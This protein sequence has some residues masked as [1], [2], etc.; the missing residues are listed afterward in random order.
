VVSGEQACR[1]T[2]PSHVE[3][4][5]WSHSNVVLAVLLGRLGCTS[6][7]QFVRFVPFAPPR[8]AAKHSDESTRLQVDADEL[9]VLARAEHPAGVSR[10]AERREV[11]ELLH[12][13]RELV[14][15]PR[16]A[17]VDV[18]VSV[19]G[20]F[21]NILLIVVVVFQ[22]G[23]DSGLVAGG[24]VGAGSPATTRALDERTSDGRAGARPPLAFV[25]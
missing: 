25:P 14:Q 7:Q 1:R 24:C 15:S 3:Q 10:E 22:S 12:R 6:R 18:D 20:R 23:S 11:D 21:D 13:E 2:G 19:A 4:I 16:R 5:L 8:A 9:G 17:R